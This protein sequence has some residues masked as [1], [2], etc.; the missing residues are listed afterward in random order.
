VR[1]TEGPVQRVL[2]YARVS[3]EEQARG[4]SLQDQQDVIA[5]H[6]KARGLKV[7]RCYVEAESAIYERIENR[8]QIQLLM[9]EVRRGDLVVC[10]KLDRWSRD[11]EF[12]Y[13]S[14]RQILER[15]AGFYAV[16]DRCDPATRD[17]D[18]MLGVRVLVAR[19]EYKRLRE[20]TIGT[21]KILR[22]KGYYVEGVVPFGY[23]RPTGKGVSRLEHNAL[24]PNGQAAD[25]VREIYRSCIGGSS[26]NAI[27]LHLRRTQPGRGW[28]KK[29]L[30]NILRNRFFVGEILDSRGIWIQGKHVALID[31]DVFARA[32]TALDSRRLCGPGPQANSRT[33][34][35]LLRQI[36]T[37][38]RCGAKVAAAYGGGTKGTHVNEIPY[39]RC[40]KH[41][42]GARYM[43]VRDFDALADGLVIGR[44]TELRKGLAVGAEPGPDPGTRSVDF[45]TERAKLQRKRER[46]IEAFGNDTGM[47]R[48]EIRAALAR[49]DAARLK[50]DAQEAQT[51]KRK[52]LA[53]A[54]LRRE[55]LDRV[56]GLR[57]AWRDGPVPAKRE[58]LRLISRSV[59]IQHGHPPMIE[60]VTPEEMSLE[61]H[62]GHLRL[63]I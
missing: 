38:A 56:A 9:R 7:Y 1:E 14:I 13:G 59:R 24:I 40:S 61:E 2:G 46:F 6:A 63:R 18:T 25:T 50:L 51:M 32:Q 43:R 58:I 54:K 49:I 60:W 11:A 19:E 16:G 3:S 35:W 52:P 28:D 34:S 22:D 39:Y 10:D 20:R 15:G 4:T 27:R 33:G 17:G 31:H 8:D 30:N 21:R 5:A 12:T 23:V 37:C 26:I 47:T 36:A 44:L 62:P 42:A 53:T 45:A 48:D 55:F 41:C 57:L 29:S